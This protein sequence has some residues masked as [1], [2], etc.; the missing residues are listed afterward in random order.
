[1]IKQPKFAGRQTLLSA[2]VIA[3]ISASAAT[4]LYAQAPAAPKPEKIE[5]TGSSI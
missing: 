2:A 5:V 3:A 4:S 1:M